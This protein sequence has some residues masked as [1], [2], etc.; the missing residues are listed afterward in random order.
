MGIKLYLKSGVLDLQACWIGHKDRYLK[1]VMS[2]VLELEQLVDNYKDKTF[3]IFGA[4]KE[5]IKTTESLMI[6]IVDLLGEKNYPEKYI[7]TTVA[8]LR[9]QR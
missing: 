3:V 9:N 7:T 5:N 2:V 6:S 4:Y 8:T 1:K